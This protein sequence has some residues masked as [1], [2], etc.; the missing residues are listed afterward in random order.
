MS[1]GLLIPAV[2]FMNFMTINPGF[3]PLLKSRIFVKLSMK[4]WGILHTRENSQLQN[5][6][7]TKIERI[8]FS[9]GLRSIH[10]IIVNSLA[11]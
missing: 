11:E 10:N 9:A 3:Y 4:K 2:H 5:P 8:K 1:L 7:S 6:D